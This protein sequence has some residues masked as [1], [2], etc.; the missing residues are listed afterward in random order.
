MNGVVPAAAVEHL[1]VLA[2]FAAA[3][4]YLALILTRRRLLK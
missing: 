1:L 2:T 4:F 3:G